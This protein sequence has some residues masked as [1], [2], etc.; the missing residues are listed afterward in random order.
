MVYANADPAGVRVQAV[1]PIRDRLASLRA[2]EVIDAYL[3]SLALEVPL[4]PGVLERES[5]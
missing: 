3:R 5:V 2:D 1:D 4:A